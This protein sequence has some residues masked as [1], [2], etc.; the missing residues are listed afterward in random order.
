[1]LWYKRF[2]RN[3]TR[4][5]A[6]V[7]DIAKAVPV[8]EMTDE[9]DI[10]FRIILPHHAYID[11]EFDYLSEPP[12]AELKYLTV[13]NGIEHHGVGTRLV[14]SFFALCEL[15][16]IGAVD[17]KII[18]PTALRIRS[19]LLGEA[20]LHISDDVDGDIVELPLSVEQAC[21]SMARA[22]LWVTHYRTY[23]NWAEADRIDTGF[24]VR[25]LMEDVNTTGWEI[26]AFAD[27][28]DHSYNLPLAA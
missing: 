4:A 8:V 22:E 15:N 17:S 9:D 21:G 20:A 27:E 28:N 12:T 6:F 19:H 10:A 18:N 13:P 24:F 11:G 3:P 23:E 1:M 14:Q 2:M 25:V 26:P 16:G 7:R 5:Q